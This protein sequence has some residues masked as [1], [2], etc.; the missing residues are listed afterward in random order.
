MV[1]IS[2]VVLGLLLSPVYFVLMENRNSYVCKQ[3]IQAISKAISLYAAENNDRLPPVFVT[4]DGI[5]PYV[6][7]D[8]G[9][10]TWAYLIRPY[11]KASASMRCPKATD[12]ECFL[13][14]DPETGKL[15]HVSYGMYLPMS[16]M[17]ISSVPNPESAVLIAETFSLGKQDSFNPFPYKDAEGNPV[18][19]GFA[20]TWDTGNTIPEA[21]KT[22]TSVTRLAYPK[23]KGGV[24]AKKGAS[25]HPGG[26]HYITV[27]GSSYTLPPDAGLVDWDSRQRK[28]QGRWTIP[29]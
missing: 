22:V 4:A 29:Q 13:D 23:S 10:Y 19:D 3:N 14:H 17:P 2:L 8:G 25:R 16:G 1:A 18:K 27:S 6:E 7:N 26:N 20:I 5:T 15:I 11:M 9:L 12:D 24:F 28:I 21:G